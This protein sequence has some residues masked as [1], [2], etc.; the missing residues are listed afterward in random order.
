MGG[1]FVARVFAGFGQR[2]GSGR[3]TWRGG[4][5]GVM[6]AVPQ[7]VRCPLGLVPG[8]AKEA[9]DECGLWLAHGGVCAR[10]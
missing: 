10:P 5:E 6:A 8:L 1:P 3:V 7:T 4:V 9:K 2:V